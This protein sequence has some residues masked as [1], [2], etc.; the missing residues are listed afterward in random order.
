VADA[1]KTLSFRPS[2]LDH[3]A[4]NF[5]ISID[6]DLNRALFTADVG[7]PTDCDRATPTQSMARHL[8]Y[9]HASSA[10]SIERVARHSAAA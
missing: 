4:S 2:A 1:L 10:H 3:P 6:I 9:A 8:S 5:A 7:V